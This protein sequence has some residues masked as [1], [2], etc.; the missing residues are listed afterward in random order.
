MRDQ[1]EGKK[2]GRPLKI[3]GVQITN[4]EGIPTTM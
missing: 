3:T 1:T 2:E 4:A